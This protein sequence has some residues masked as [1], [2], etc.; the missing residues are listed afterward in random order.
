MSFRR[1]LVKVIWRFVPVLCFALSG[2]AGSYPAYVADA[3]VDPPSVELVREPSGETLEIYQIDTQPAPKRTIFFVSGSGC[4]S[5]RYYLR[6]YFSRLPGSWRV[7]AL[8]KSG[9]DPFTTGLAGCSR[10]FDERNTLPQIWVRN[11]DALRWVVARRGKV[12]AV[13]GVSEGGALAAA[14]AAESKD[15]ERLVVIGSGG[16]TTREGLGILARKGGFLASAEQLRSG[17]EAVDADPR[18]TEKRFLGLP[19]LYWSSTL[20]RDPIPIYLRVSQPSF[21]FFGEKDQSVPVESAY[22]LRDR[23]AAAGKS[24]IKVEIVGGASHTLVR[25]GVDLKPEIFSRVGE[26]LRY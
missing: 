6:S 20:D 21:V 13:M 5:L 3:V 8:Q 11:R 10:R 4:A 22:L 14:L 12:D 26:W 9:V 24:N 18:S 19:H 17:L 23:L 25:D 16:M 7:F 2:C 15:V 1:P